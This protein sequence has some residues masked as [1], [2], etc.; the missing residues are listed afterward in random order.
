MLQNDTKKHPVKLYS[1]KVLIFGGVQNSKLCN[2]GVKPTRNSEKKST[3]RRA[4]EI[5]VCILVKESVGNIC[6]PDSSDDKKDDGEEEEQTSG[7]YS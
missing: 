1:E 7:V 3:T 4:Q 5:Y 2:R 6:G